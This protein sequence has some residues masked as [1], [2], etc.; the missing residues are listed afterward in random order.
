M[1]QLRAF[2]AAVGRVEEKLRS[3]EEFFS[4]RAE[5]YHALAMRTA[6]ATLDSLRPSDV[7]HESWERRCEEIVH[8]IGWALV[9]PSIFRLQIKTEPGNKT[10]II[11]LDDVMRWI[12]AGHAGEPGGK[13]ITPEDEA[14]LNDPTT[15]RNRANII[16]KAYYSD[17]PGSTHPRL[18]DAIQDFLSGTL[19]EDPDTLTAAIATAWESVFSQRVSEDLLE[20]A[21]HGMQSALSSAAA[22]HG[23]S[24]T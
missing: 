9:S 5:D 4:Q 18:R 20:W 23:E 7:D 12:E 3:P 8:A 24:S 6:R 19:N 2:A 15:R 13:R 21:H 17:Q 14:D 1:N 10:Q 16:K 11:S 22:A